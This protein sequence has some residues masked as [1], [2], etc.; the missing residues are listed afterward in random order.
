MWRLPGALVPAIFAGTNQNHQPKKET[1]M[2]FDQQKMASRRKFLGAF[3]TGAAAVGAATLANPIKAA[4]NGLRISSGHGIEDWFKQIKGEHRIVFDAPEFNHGM[5][6]AFPRVFQITNNG[7]GVENK[8]LGIVIVFRHNA[9]PLALNSKMWEKYKLGEVFGINDPVTDK[10]STRNFFWQPKAGALEIPGMGIN[11]LQDTGVMF[12]GCEMAILHYS[13]V[14][15]KKM[16][17]DHETVRKEWLSEMLPKVQ[18]VP[19]GVFAVNRAQ[20]HGCTYC[21]AG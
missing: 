2:K 13:G 21:F 1:D 3:A 20:E 15:A 5:P 17:L 4:G 11:E 19:S 9:I 12:C 6:L 8:D 7:A 14:V 16:G 10:P 18:P